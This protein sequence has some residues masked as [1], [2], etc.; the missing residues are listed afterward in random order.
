[1]LIEVQSVKSTC[2]VRSSGK[3][4]AG[5][6]KRRFQPLRLKAW[7][8]SHQAINQRNTLTS[9]SFCQRDIYEL[10]P[11][12]SIGDSYPCHQSHGFHL[13]LRPHMQGRLVAKPVSETIHEITSLPHHLL[14]TN[15]QQKSTYQDS[16]ASISA[17]SYPLHKYGIC[18]ET[19]ETHVS[20]GLKTLE[21]DRPT[22]IC[23]TTPHKLPKSIEEP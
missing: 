6:P 19:C 15:D 2:G 12:V 22:E 10:L 7:R 5:P 4:H 8:I 13:W 17:P 11:K 14:P 16:N 20:T 21:I 23:A 3:L 9:E 1:M 18:S